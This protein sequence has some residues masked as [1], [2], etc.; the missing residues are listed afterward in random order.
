MR[1]WLKKIPYARRLNRYFR[2][3]AYERQFSGDCYGG[4]RGVYET[5]DQAI[6]SA[7]KTKS[8][9]YNDRSLAQEYRENAERDHHIRFFDYPVLFWLNQILQAGDSNRKLVDLGGNVGVLFYAFAKYIQYPPGLQWI[10]WDVPE[11]VNAGRELAEERKASHLVFTAN[12]EEAHGAD[13]FLASGS[14]QYIKDWSSPI[15]SL[16][17]KPKHLI[18]NHIPVYDGSPFV[19]LQNGGKVFYPQHVF[20]R[21]RFIGVMSGLGYELIDV[22]EDRGGVC[23]I[24]FYPER[25]LHNF[26]GFY[27]KLKP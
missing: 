4:F 17:A 23:R 8:V 27:F 5:F 18:I 2:K 9:G 26:N 3:L 12:V 16:P 14:I 22:W 24:P 21:A 15:S 20:N 6:L 7:P 25:S 11:I 10:V 19:T 1:E 13:I